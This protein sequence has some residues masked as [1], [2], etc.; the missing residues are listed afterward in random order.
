MACRPE[1]IFG[2]GRGAETPRQCFRGVRVAL[3]CIRLRLPRRQYSVGKGTAQRNLGTMFRRGHEEHYR[4][5]RVIRVLDSEGVDVNHEYLG[6]KKVSTF[7]E[8]LLGVYYQRKGEEPIV[9]EM[10]TAEPFR[11]KRAV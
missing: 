1:N 10:G 7:A 8:R 11:N 6:P 5:V 4:D 2:Y 3:G 9:E